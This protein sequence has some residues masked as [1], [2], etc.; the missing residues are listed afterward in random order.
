MEYD[1]SGLLIFTSPQNEKKIQLF[2]VLP[3]K[4]KSFRG[5]NLLLS[6][7]F[8]ERQEPL[9]TGKGAQGHA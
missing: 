1:I 9:P 6:C 3:F 2:E 5:E 7:R 8:D 4:I